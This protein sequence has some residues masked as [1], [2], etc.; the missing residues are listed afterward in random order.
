MC[1]KA[2]TLIELLVVV[3]IIAVLIAIL[4]PSLARARSVARVVACSSNIHQLV[5]LTR[6]YAN[7]NR[8]YL[9]TGTG[10]G[11]YSDL[12]NFPGEA[13]KMREHGFG[14]W[15]GLG[16]LYYRK[17]LMDQ[18]LFFCADSPLKMP[19]PWPVP[20]PTSK[21]VYGSYDY[22]FL[23]TRTGG[24][25]NRHRLYATLS[26]FRP[27]DP[28]IM[29]IASRTQYYAHEDTK[30]WNV[31]LSDGSVDYKVNQAIFDDPNNPQ[32]NFYLFVQNL[33]KLMPIP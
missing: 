17:Y 6:M 4:I 18:R 13:Q 15:W 24:A 21:T 28:I 19:D 3:A 27:G 32:Q 14:Y 30:G 8:Q 22:N 31:G 1:R 20:W 2:F 10:F 9:M 7:D 12:L 25:L 16:R 5:S 29:D 33:E 11:E 26:E 23:V